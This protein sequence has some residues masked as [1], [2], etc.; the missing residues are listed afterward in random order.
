M[1]VFLK[2]VQSAKGWKLDRSKLK[3]YKTNNYFIEL[4]EK[5]FYF[6]FFLLQNKE[7]VVSKE[8]LLK[9]VW[10]FST[11]YN[12][13]LLNSRVVE[14]IVSRIRKKLKKFKQGPQLIKNKE[15]YKLLI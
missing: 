8:R 2:N 4:T 11:T 9:K 3:F 5:E 6:L 7:N 12:T 10:G 14:T 15:G 1:K 13:N